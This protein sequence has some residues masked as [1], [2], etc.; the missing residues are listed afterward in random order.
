MSWEEAIVGDVAE[1]D[2]KGI[3]GD[4]EDEREVGIECRTE[5]EEEEEAVLE[6]LYPLAPRTTPLAIFRSTCAI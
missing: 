4:A 2:L 6:L 5:K 1:K 3:E